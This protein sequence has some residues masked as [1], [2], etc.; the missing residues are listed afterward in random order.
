MSRE[1]LLIYGHT[2]H[3]RK[4]HPAGIG[5][6]TNGVKFCRQ[7]QE[8]ASITMRDLYELYGGGQRAFDYL[9]REATTNGSRQLM[10]QPLVEIDEKIR[11]Q[12][13]E[14]MAREIAERGSPITAIWSWDAPTATLLRRGWPHRAPLLTHVIITQPGDRIPEQI[15]QHATLSLCFSPLARQTWIDQGLPPWK[16]F[17]LPHHY[18]ELPEENGPKRDPN[19]LVIGC[20]ARFNVLK[21]IDAILWAV[22]E[23]HQR[24]PHIRLRLKGDYDN[25]WDV[26]EAQGYTEQMRH[27]M[28]RFAGEPW[29][30]WDA[31]QSSPEETLKLM[32]SFD[33]G[34]NMTGCELASTVAVE[35]L[36]L[37]IPLLLLHGTTSD[38]LFEGSCAWVKNQG[39]AKMRRAMS[40]IDIPDQRDLVN[41]L[42]KLILDAQLR[43]KLS[44]RGRAFAKA[45]FSAERARAKTNL[46]LEATRALYEGRE[47]ASWKE[48]LIA[49]Q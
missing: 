28:E 13:E 35:M 5:E 4:V 30:I 41:Q 14:T 7:A 32:R 21:N 46:L 19:R 17:Y 16:C 27:L 48:R 22:R 9:Y 24:H 3:S 40:F 38:S 34:V 12:A 49:E 29:L 36:A 18:P 45:N 37:G 11:T 31:K 8:W 42:E 43:K 20:V 47:T 44:E 15:H 33:I 6:I 2:D 26:A 39:A 23:L 1:E 10:G 25:S